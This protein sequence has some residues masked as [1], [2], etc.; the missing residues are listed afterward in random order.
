MQ[1]KYTT[2]VDYPSQYFHFQT[3]I[4]MSAV[5]VLTGHAHSFPASGFTYCDFGCGKA[6]T[7]CL[8]AACNPK[9]KFFGVDINT[10][11][12]ASAQRL[13]EQV[14]LNNVTLI[15]TDFHDLTQEDLP[16]LDYAAVT[17]VLSWVPDKTRSNL[18]QYVASRLKSGG[19]AF[20]HY[21]S[22][23]GL[24]KTLATTTL[25]QLLSN[26]SSG[27]SAS[28]AVDA[29]TELQNILG[30]NPYLAFNQS[31]PQTRDAL[32]QQLKMEP[33]YLAHDVLNR[34]LQ[35]MWF[36]QVVD[37][38]SQKGLEFVGNA[39]P[40]MNAFGDLYQT[41]LTKP[42]HEFCKKYEDSILRQEMMGLL[43]N[44]SVRMDIFSKKPART[45]AHKVSA[46]PNLRIISL[47][48]R[49]HEAVRKSTTG[50]VS[51]NMFEPVYN[52]IMAATAEH[53]EEAEL[54]FE[55]CARK[56]GAAETRRALLNLL[57]VN[58]IT[59]G[60]HSSSASVGEQEFKPTEIDKYMLSEFLSESG[61]APFPSK[62]LGSCIRLSQLERILL[63]ALITEDP[64]DVWEMV[65]RYRIK[66]R[67]VESR[68]I[69][70]CDEFLK[71][72]PAIMQ[73]FQTQRLPELLRLGLL[74]S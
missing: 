63:T 17:G 45:D 39:R 2:D 47:A 5:A 15:E 52:E 64:K 1:Q 38:L 37:D 62:I 27:D 21:L 70:S 14:G 71:T 55:E 68:E 28:R 30:K 53:D 73:S 54:I 19:L 31:S 41:S 29:V 24:T 8:L 6:L 4:L 35:P 50:H 44:L 20:I 51:I 18:L 33:N 43:L 59:F 67:T 16:A 65:V 60:P 11:H 48:G 25:T 36:H 40:E 23:P 61:Q 57:A 56:Y 69:T 46:F 7:L 34:N 49:S 32:G 26:Q 42:Y 58:L 22:M 74:S 10:D 9:G 3:P 12:I 72:L 13:V 66:L